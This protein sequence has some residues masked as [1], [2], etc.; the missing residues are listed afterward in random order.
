[1]SVNI[2]DFL[3]SSY[4]G[5]IGFTGSQGTTGDTGFTGSQGASGATGF[6]GSIGFT[7]SQGTTGFTGSFGNTGFTGSAGDSADVTITNDTSTNDTRYV[8]FVA[9]T[10][11]D[12]AGLGVSNTKMTFNPSTGTFSVT[13][14]TETSSRRYKK[15]ITPIVN[16][17]SAIEQLQ[18]VTFDRNDGDI[19]NSSGLIAEDVAEILPN[20][21]NFVDGKPDS[22]YYTRIIAY[23]VEAIKELSDKIDGNS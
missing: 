19:I 3:S 11:G 14:I 5:A 1:M 15:N 17:L 12:V 13:A 9:E 16:A 4:I 22:I 2:S 8:T 10:S 21:V 23:L 6:T 20:L 18:G 7:G